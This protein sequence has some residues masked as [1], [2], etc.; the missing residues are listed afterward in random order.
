MENKIISL[1]QRLTSEVWEPRVEQGVDTLPRQGKECRPLQS[2][3]FMQ[4]F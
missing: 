1:Q 3:I 4:T 2:E